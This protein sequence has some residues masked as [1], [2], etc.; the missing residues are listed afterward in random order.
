MPEILKSVPNLYYIIAGD[1]PDKIYLKEWSNL[2]PGETI[3]FKE[4]GSGV[5]YLFPE[6]S[7]K[8]NIPSLFGKDIRFEIGDTVAYG[9]SENY[10]LKIIT[11]FSKS[12]DKRT[13]SIGLADT[14][15]GTP[16]FV[17]YLSDVGFVVQR[18]RCH[19][20]GIYVTGLELIRKIDL[21]MFGKHIKVVASK[22]PGLPKGTQCKIIGEFTD[23]FGEILLL[24]NGYTIRK[25]DIGTFF[26]LL[27]PT[28]R[29]YFE[30][31]PTDLGGQIRI[32]LGD[33]F[34]QR[35][36]ASN[37]IFL[38]SKN[39]DR[40]KYYTPPDLNGYCSSE[41][42]LSNQKISGFVSPR[43][44]SVPDAAKKRYIIYPP[45]R[46]NYPTPDSSAYYSIYERS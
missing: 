26:R 39:N 33:K 16:E 24:H 45:V 20:Y 4:P 13:L 7:T 32:S 29:E 15:D 28:S 6:G 18:N 42:R 25:S 46:N 43:I 36:A 44:Q 27:E 40:N 31:I 30:I 14:V 8:L 34:K 11:G 9:S 12:E 1:G 17:P 21:T 23:C 35:W 3:S 22:I 10:S 38:S 41:H 37:Y 5:N 19:L 2:N